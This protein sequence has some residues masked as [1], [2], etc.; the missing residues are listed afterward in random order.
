MNEIK[1]LIFFHQLKH[2]FQ[3]RN[4][5][6]ENL[7]FLTVDQALADTAHFVSY[8]KS[9]YVTPGTEHSPVIVIGYH[10]SASLAVWFRQKYPHLVLAA[11]ASSAPL[12]SVVNNVE[13][14]ELAGAVYRSVGGNEC[15]DKLEEGYKQM[16][17][18]VAE[19]KLDVLSRIFNLCDPLETP[20]DVG[21][22]FAAISDFYSLFSQ[23]SK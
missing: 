7:R 8:I 1:F 16:E 10:Y 12:L 17:Q 22:F 6:T 11:W 20:N 19:E 3:Y 4:V 18:L 15:Y 21:I 14:K 5:S 2:Y 23:F 13:F 9:E